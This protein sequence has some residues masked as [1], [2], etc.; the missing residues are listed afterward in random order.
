[1]GSSTSA[2]YPSFRHVTSCWL[3]S[4][5][6]RTPPSIRRA[7]TVMLQHASIIHHTTPTTQGPSPSPS[8][9]P[10]LCRIPSKISLAHLARSAALARPI[11]AELKAQ[12]NSTQSRLIIITVILIKHSSHASSP[13]REPQQ[14]EPA[15]AARSC[16]RHYVCAVQASSRQPPWQ[17]PEQAITGDDEPAVESHAIGY[18]R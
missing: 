13:S 10:T 5:L 8:P 7:G 4:C 1:M 17:P 2:A 16:V 14:S 11:T 9:S 15:A 6:P 3:L 18:P 12:S